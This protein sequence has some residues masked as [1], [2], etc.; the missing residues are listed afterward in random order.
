MLLF[1]F[2]NAEASKHESHETAKKDYHHAP[3]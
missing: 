3:L 1:G 2:D